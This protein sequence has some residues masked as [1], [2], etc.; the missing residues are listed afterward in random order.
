[1]DWSPR[2]MERLYELYQKHFG[3]LRSVVI[4]AN[5]VHGSSQ[6]EKTWME[7]ISR[8]E[9]ERLLNNPEEPELAERWVRRIVRGHEHEFPTLRVA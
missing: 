6:P 3:D 7:L 2:E 5:R 4:A 8:D 1:M 9:F